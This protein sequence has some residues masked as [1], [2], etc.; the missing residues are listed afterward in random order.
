MTGKPK[1][2]SFSERQ[3]LIKTIVQIDGMDRPL[4]ASLWNIIHQTLWGDKVPTTHE[5]LFANLEG[6]DTGDVGYT[7]VHN[8]WLG[9]F[10]EP[11][12]EL[13]EHTGSWRG[14]IAAVKQRFFSLEWNR[15][16]DLIEYLVEHCPGEQE[17]KWL[18]PGFN[19][20]LQEHCSAYR[21]SKDGLVLPVTSSE[22][23]AT[24]D[25]AMAHDACGPYAGTSKHIAT[26]AKLLRQRDF[27]NSVKESI[28]AV[29][30]AVKAIAEDKK[31]DFA[32]LLKSIGLAHPALVKSFSSL[33]GY[34]SDAD[35]IRHALASPADDSSLGADEA[36]FFLV[37]CSAFT[38]LL[39]A[40][41]AL[42]K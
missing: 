29:E 11:I 24:I 36:I 20:V 40:K 27:R 10:H 6:I 17:A 33:Y 13:T 14:L 5:E 19:H 26:A 31:S 37:N 23:L 22:E 1:R 16:Y 38:N 41:A 3:G 32:S 18:V 7:A 39:I 8:L 15:I 9:F 25:K 34:T 4:R 21:L 30:S 2:Q 12:D 35:G 42:R 28:S